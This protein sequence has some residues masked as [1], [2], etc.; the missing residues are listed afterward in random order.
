[1]TL[2]LA[3]APGAEEDLQDA[4]AFY[5]MQ[6]PGLGESF[7]RALDDGLARVV[8]HPNSFRS[9]EHGVRTAFLHRFPYGIRFRLKAD[10]VQVLAVWHERRRPDGWR[11][12]TVR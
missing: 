5:E 6:R 12:R 10:R 11:S 9:D 8:S 4:F 2:T 3:L 7:L 1:M